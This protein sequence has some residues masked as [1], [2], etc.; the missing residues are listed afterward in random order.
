MAPR[1]G[2]DRIMSNKTFWKGEWRLIEQPSPLDAKGRLGPPCSPFVEG[3]DVKWVAEGAYG[4]SGNF[5]PAMQI[6][7]PLPPMPGPGDRTYRVVTPADPWFGGKFGPEKLEERLDGLG[8][9]GWRAV[10]IAGT[11]AD[12][13]VLLERVI[14]DALVADERRRRGAPPA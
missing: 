4:A 5:V 11:R 10:G 13:V 1:A 7:A 9:E 2:K 8:R 14:D 3:D 6:A 12:P